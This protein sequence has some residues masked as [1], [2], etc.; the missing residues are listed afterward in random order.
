MA[1]YS[2]TIS[3]DLD[4]SE[5]TEVHTALNRLGRGVSSYDSNY[6]RGGVTKFAYETGGWIDG[7]ESTIRQAVE[8]ALGGNAQIEV[9]KSSY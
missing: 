6:S 5:R 4:K 9:S 1:L 2:I 3:K 7:F 8:R